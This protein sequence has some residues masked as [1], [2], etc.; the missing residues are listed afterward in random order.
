M[1]GGEP[2]GDRAGD[3]AAARGAAP[4]RGG[5]REALE[6]ERR[7]LRHGR[8]GVRRRHRHV[9]G[10]RAGQQ[11]RPAGPRLA[12]RRRPSRDQDLRQQRPA[13]GVADPRSGAPRP[14]AVRGG[15]GRPP[16][17]RGGARPG[18]RGPHR[19]PGPPPVALARRRPSR[20][21]P[22]LSP[23]HRC[24]GAPPDGR[25]RGGEP[26]GAGRRGLGGR[27][28]RR[29][30]RRAPGHRRSPAARRPQP[31]DRRPAAG[32]GRPE[33]GHLRRRRLGGQAAVRGADAGPVPLARAGRGRHHH[34]PR[35]QAGLRAGRGP[36]AARHEEARRGRAAVRRSHDRRADHAVAGRQR[37]RD[38]AAAAGRGRRHRPHPAAAGPEPLAGLRR[39][40]LHRFGDRPRPRQHRARRPAHGGHAPAVPAERAVHADRGPGDSRE[41]GGH[42]PRDVALRPHAQRDQPRRH[43]L[44]GG[45]AR[46]Q[47]GGRAGEHLH[48]LERRRG[49]PHGRRPR[50]RRGVGRRPRQLA[51]DGGGLSAGHLREGGGRAALRRHR[52]GDQRGGAAL[53]RRLRARRARG[54]G[55]A[56]GREPAAGRGG[57]LP[58]CGRRGRPGLHGPGAAA[59]RLAPR[60]PAAAD[61]GGGFHRGCRRGRHLAH[62][63]QGRIPARGQPQP[64]VR[65]P[66][67]PPGLQHR[68]AAADGRR[69]RGAVDPVLGRRSGHA[70]GGGPRFPRPRRRLLRGPGSFGVHGP[71]RP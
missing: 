63:A 40:H 51:H 64:R 47:R 44:R 71:P 58:R 56:F 37:A 38:D 26:A 16:R 60:H 41:R 22:L 9:A 8:A 18:G 14:R 3:R 62:A 13:G 31:H 4:Q 57:F 66:P 27:R 55:L 50:R 54:R 70:G 68:R 19:R 30:A 53:A 67:A 48:P 65:D 61:A 45:H 29:P 25:G 11:P 5:A 35:R 2:A 46:G 42:V 28:R 52:P 20:T 21:R 32:P 7:F 49:R 1:A 43:G 34:A 6:R 39:D 69:R 15:A 17:A 59:R 33:P 10:A 23:G 24:R 36:R 12:D